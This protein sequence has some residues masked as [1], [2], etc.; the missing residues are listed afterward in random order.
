M[1][2][3]LLFTGVLV[4][5]FVCIL[6][7]LFIL[8][9][10]PNANAGMGSALGGAATESVFGGETM[11]VLT[12]TTSVLITIFFLLCIGLYFAFV[13]R[14]ERQAA[15]AADLT[16][17]ETQAVEEQSLYTDA[18]GNPI[19]MEPVPAEQPANPEQ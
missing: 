6:A 9:Q 19:S 1:Y 11:S 2:N 7:V 16:L 10:R 4:L 3:I 17:Q 13:A 18:D 5:V 12:K 8:M 15:P 14:G